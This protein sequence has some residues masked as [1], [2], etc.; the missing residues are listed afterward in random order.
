MGVTNTNSFCCDRSYCDEFCSN[1]FRCDRSYCKEFC[2]DCFCWDDR[3]SDEESK[4]IKELNN[5]FSSVYSV[6]QALDNLSHFKNFI[7]DDELNKGIFGKSLKK[8][9]KKDVNKDLDRNSR[10]I[11]HR[12]YKLN[13]KIIGKNPA[14][15][16]IQILDLLNQE[17]SRNEIQNNE[18]FLSKIKNKNLSNNYSNEK[19]LYKHLEWFI[20]NNN[21]KIGEYF[22][23]FFQKKITD[24][25]GVINFDYE[26]KFIFEL[27]LY[28]IF[29]E[30]SRNR[31]LQF[32]DN[33]IPQL[34][35]IECIKEYCSPKKIQNIIEEQ[36]LYATPAYLI[37]I[38]NREDNKNHYFFGNFNYDDTI[39]LSSI[40]LRENNAKKYKL[41]SVIKE[42]KIVPEINEYQEIEDHYNFDYITIN[43]DNNGQ[44][45][46]Y[47][48]N[49]KIL[50]EFKNN[51][52]FDNILI[53]RQEKEKI[54][55][56]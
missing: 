33:N 6:L 8:I 24:N 47:E 18:T 52:Y 5:D 32:N 30:K 43:R 27:K 34:Y 19:A 4:R 36:S 9:F 29:K 12:I 10:I 46:Y 22:F 40:I 55:S 11:Y 56:Y 49:N 23:I 1:S 17:Q 21:N 39:D 26:H 45:Y 14:K 31:T 50:G 28:D 44:F 37:F 13:N 48:N 54:E 38:L 41:S 16:I 35:L 15:I 53:F 3:P 20:N 25:F 7:L 51:K 42:K 2:S